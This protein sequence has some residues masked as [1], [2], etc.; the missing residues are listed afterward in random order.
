[1]ATLPMSEK[2]KAE[3][4]KR[5]AEEKKAAMKKSMD[6][7]IGLLAGVLV[8]LAIVIWGLFFR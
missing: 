6:K 3:I 8:I 7:L 1:M 5:K 4:E 2:R